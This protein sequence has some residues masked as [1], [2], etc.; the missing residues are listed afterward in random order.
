[1][2]KNLMSKLLDVSLKSIYNFEKQ[3]RPIIKL[4]NYFSDN[5]AEELLEIGKITR[6][7]NINFIE[8]IRLSEI[9]KLLEKSNIEFLCNS[10][11][12]YIE[13]Y[14]GISGITKSL[15]SNRSS[16]LEFL[17][18]LEKILLDLKWEITKSEN[19]IFQPVIKDFNQDIGFDFNHTDTNIIRN[20]IQRYNV[21]NTLYDLDK[22]D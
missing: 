10:L 7:E 9:I 22:T 3:N 8:Y 13:I 18:D 17:R 12:K 11:A 14:N 5:D 20:I 15:R 16:K 4:L 19:N 1:M 21:Y 2:H 6:L